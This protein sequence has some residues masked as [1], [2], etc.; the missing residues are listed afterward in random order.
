MV[1]IR[2]DHL[3]FTH[4]GQ[5][6]TLLEDLSFTI[7]DRSRVGLIGDNGCGK[8]T[9]FALLRG[10]LRASSG[11]V[12]AKDGLSLGYLPQETADVS[13]PIFEESGTGRIERSPE[14]GREL[15]VADYLWSARPELAALKTQIDSYG[16]AA[17]MAYSELIARFD[18]MGGYR[19]EAI[20][21]K[22]LAGFDLTA[23]KLTL[24]LANLSG[25]EKTKTA[26]CRL[27]LR[28]PDLLILD[29]PTNHLE[30]ATLTWLEEYLCASRVPY[31]VI[32]HDRHFLDAC[33]ESIWELSDRTLSFYAGN[34]SFYSEQRDQ[35]IARQQHEHKVQ[36]RKVKQLK[37]DLQ[38]RKQWAASHQAQT[39][40]EGRAPVY[41]NVVNLARKAAQRAKNMEARIERMI[42]QEEGKSPRLPRERYITL[43]SCPLKNQTVLTLRGL[44]KSLGEHRVFES[45][46]LA[47]AN[48]AR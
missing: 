7:D 27:L 39:G 5:V 36:Q 38:R 42:D 47:L 22:M 21:E 46:D 34:Y 15:S 28:E 17:D 25:G 16:N 14:A 32:S 13:S 33:S 4:E 41:E 43:E 26:L 6:E 2:A 48:G 23:D 3:T 24:P 37:K 11:S 20:F 35:E 31:V 29:E 19:F 30:I 45:I 8:T 9:L 44:G 12:F 10:V 18:E 40:T 1:L